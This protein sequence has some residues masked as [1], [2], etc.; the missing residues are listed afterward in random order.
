MN[1]KK[2]SKLLASSEGIDEVITFI[3]NAD[4]KNSEYDLS[5]GGINSFG[6]QLM[7]EGKDED[8]LKI[9]KMNTELYPEAY[10]T[11]DSYGE[12]LVKIGRTKEGIA[13]YKKSIEL[14]PKNEN[15][16]KIIAELEK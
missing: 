12:C 3:K 9:F 8:A 11:H 5:E 6:Y 13:A 16:K 7:G 2:L 15:A 14:N 1:K 10:N 4:L